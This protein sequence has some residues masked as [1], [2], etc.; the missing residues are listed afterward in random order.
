MNR[1]APIAKIGVLMAVAAV[2]FIIVAYHHPAIRST[3]IAAVKN[4]MAATWKPE[5]RPLPK[6]QPAQPQMTAQAS[7]PAQP[8]QAAQPCQPCTEVWTRWRQAAVDGFGAQQQQALEL[9]KVEQIPG[10]PP[11]IGA[12][13]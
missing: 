8:R 5:D 10:P 7:M 1:M 4:P 6:I 2:I 9:P 3:A 11:M 13:P 12:M